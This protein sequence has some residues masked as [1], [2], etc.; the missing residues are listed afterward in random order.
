MP[1]ICTTEHKFVR[2]GG[3]IEIIVS[4]AK[5]AEIFVEA[6]FERVKLR[7]VPE[8]RFAK[9]AGR[10]TDFLESVADGLFL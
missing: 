8:V 4:T 1:G 7:E 10:V 3:S 6:A 2:I 9:P 5:E